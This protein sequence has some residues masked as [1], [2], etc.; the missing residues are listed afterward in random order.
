[1]V[2]SGP[3]HV[4]SLGSQHGNPFVNPEWRGDHGGSVHIAHTNRS[5]PRG[6]TYISQAKSNK[7][8]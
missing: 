2:G 4:E 1:M 6:G 5:Q 7:D 8:L 3:H